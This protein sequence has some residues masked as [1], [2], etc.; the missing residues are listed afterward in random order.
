MASPSRSTPLSSGSTSSCAYG[1]Y[2]NA[3]AGLGNDGRTVDFFAAAGATGVYTEG[4]GSSRFNSSGGYDSY[5][6]PQLQF[7]HLDLNAG[8]P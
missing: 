3:D 7:N 5:Q 6:N 8:E 2:G 1:A 4:A